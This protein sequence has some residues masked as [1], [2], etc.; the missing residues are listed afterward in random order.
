MTTAANAYRV[1][2]SCEV[3]H[4]F[5]VT[6]DMFEDG[7][8]SEV[9]DWSDAGAVS[10]FLESRGGREALEQLISDRTVFEV[11]DIWL[12]RV[13]PLEVAA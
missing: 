8:G 11:E 5:V 7:D 10:D 13:R 6:P 12:R 4:R 3:H 1:D 9:V 2:V